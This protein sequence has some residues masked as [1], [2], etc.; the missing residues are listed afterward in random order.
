MV[1]L[2]P[3]QILLSQCGQW[4]DARNTTMFKDGLHPTA[5]GY[6][7]IMGCLARQVGTLLAARA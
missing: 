4:L 1:A 6:Q 7:V 3:P 5:A 2:L